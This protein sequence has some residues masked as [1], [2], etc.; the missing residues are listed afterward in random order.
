MK[1]KSGVG[2]VFK[3][4]EEDGISAM[5]PNIV[6]EINFGVYIFGGLSRIIFPFNGGDAVFEFLNILSGESA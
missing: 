5:F 1:A 6:M 4:A 3:G 2:G